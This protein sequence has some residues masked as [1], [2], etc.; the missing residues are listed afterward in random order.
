MSNPTQQPPR[1][2]RAAVAGSAVVLIAAG[3]LFYYASK[4]ASEKRKATAG[5][6]ITVTIHPKQCEPNAL[7][8]PAGKTTF[9]IV[10]ASDRAVEWEILDGVLVVEERENITP[11]LSQVINANLEPGEY[12]ITCGLLSNPRGTL[13]VTAT[14]ESEARAKARPEMT[15]FI[16]PL[17]EYRVYLSI[18]GSSL[19]QGVDALT[20][21]IDAGDLA[22]ARAAYAPARAAYQRIAP[23]AQRFAELNNAIDARADYYEKREQDPSFT[24]FHRLEYGLFQQSSVEGLAAVTHRLQADVTTLKTQLLATPIP[25]DQLVSIVSRNLRTLADNRFNGEEERY[26]HLDLNGF[27]ANLEG[28]GKVIDLMHPLLEKRAASLVT[29]LDSNRQAFKAQLDALREG[30][31]YRAYDK[32]GDDQRKA[33]ASAAKALADSL[34]GIDQALGLSAL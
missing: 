33:L 15:A 24:G 29:Q 5:S 17:S 32:V 22:A 26:S 1:L 6:E 8:V 20:K 31:G 27:A 11:G 10:N 7:T 21:A 23:A 30:D 9:R 34:D 25:P 18:Q 28:A 16:G 2:L 3:G 4:V 12:A 13:K 14:A 19:I